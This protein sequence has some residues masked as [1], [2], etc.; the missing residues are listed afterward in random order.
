VS[1]DPILF[2][3]RQSNLYVYVGND[4]VNRR[5]PFGLE[6]STSDPFS[7]P[8][9]TFEDAADAAERKF[10]GGRQGGHNT[11]GDAYRHC[12]ASCNLTQSF[13]SAYAS[14]WGWLNE[15]ASFGP[16]SP[17]DE[18]NMDAHNNACG[19]DYGRDDD[20]DCSLRCYS[21]AMGGELIVLEP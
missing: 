20:I 1:K 9:T 11:V 21:A 15:A 3:G 7:A 2:W 10:G 8:F 14:F 19:R 17:A 5:D 13:G 6:A 18:A 16:P 4:P 12:V